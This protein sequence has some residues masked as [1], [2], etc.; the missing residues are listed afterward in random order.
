M[1]AQTGIQLDR[2]KL[3]CSIC[4]ELLEDPVTILCGHNYCM[5]C[6]ES[7]WDE[8]DQRETYSCPQCRQTFRPRPALVKN[9]MLADLAE[10]Q[11]TPG[12]QADP[13]DLCRTGPGDVVCDSCTGRKMKAVKSCLQCLVSY[14]EQHLQPHYESPAFGKHKLVE[15]SVKLQENIC[16]L[17]NEVMKI[18]CRTDQQ[19][20][21]FLCSMDE[22]K[23]HDMVSAAAGMAEK[24]KE[25]GVN[26]Y[27]TEQRIQEREEQVKVLQQEVEVINQYADEAVRDSEKIFAD[28]K[29]QIRSRQKSEVAHVQ[30]L[31]EMLQ[32]EIA[33]LRR[34]NSELEQL[35]RTEDP[36]QFLHNYT[37]LPRLGEAAGSLSVGIHSQRYGEDVKAA[38]SQAED[39][40]QDVV[41]EEWTRMS[42]DMD[43]LQ[44]QTEPKTREDFLKYSCELTLNPNTSHHHVRVIELCASNYPV[45]YET[46]RD[47][48]K[49]RHPDRFTDWPQVLCRESLTERCY[50]EVELKE[51]DIFIAVAYA[52]ISR[53][54]P[55]SAFGNNNRSWALE[56]F[57]GGF[58]FR[59]NNIRT[60]P[61]PSCLSTVGVYLDHRAGILA[62]YN[63]FENMTLLHTW[64]D[65]AAMA[66]GK[67]SKSKLFD[68]FDGT[69]KKKIIT[70]S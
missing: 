28:V 67:H 59:H 7:H 66:C 69:E 10:L 38:V 33:V 6:I 26:I 65:E 9:T 3:N 34:R 11:K 31:Q 63:V 21:C 70:I 50:W 12:P 35:K 1:A 64:M 18:F 62:F 47:Y 41:D 16:S 53:R 56:C 46:Y 17:H 30:E 37:M 8:E 40:L 42:L 13:A 29:Q 39:N 5:K 32:Q 55:E 23:G 48:E 4:L 57:G 14:C 44:P 2:E 25:L 54:G 68:A 36:T 45:D 43:V 22:H 24:Q 49:H 52:N 60:G 51:F 58:N 15:P 27:T 19:C 20:I 61:Q